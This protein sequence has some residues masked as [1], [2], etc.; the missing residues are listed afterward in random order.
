MRKIL[1]NPASVG[2]DPAVGP[3]QDYPSLPVY[4][5]LPAVLPQI[6]GQP[7]KERAVHR[8][9]TFLAAL[10]RHPE[11]DIATICYTVVEISCPPSRRGR[12]HLQDLGVSAWTK[13][14]T[15]RGT[16]VSTDRRCYASIFQYSCSSYLSH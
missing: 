4:D 12:V 9:D 14:F 5:S 6:G 13:F 15:L 7:G 16:P 8:V 1:R 11:P 3:A 2:G 10:A